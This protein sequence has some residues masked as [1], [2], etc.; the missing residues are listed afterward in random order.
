MQSPPSH[1]CL[2]RNLKKNSIL[3]SFLAAFLFTS[4]GQ[5]FG[6]NLKAA[7]VNDNSSFALDI[8]YE[9]GS[10]PSVLEPIEAGLKSQIIFTIQLCEK[11]EGF[12]SFLGDIVLHEETVQY[13]G[14]KDFF[15]KV[16][17][18]EDAGGEKT[19][20][21]NAE[22]FFYAFRTLR[23]YSVN[24]Y[25]P[26]EK[27]PRLFFRVQVTVYQVKLVAPLT[28][29]YSFSKEGVFESGWKTITFP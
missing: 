16:Y 20:F 10:F 3:L 29:I 4:I 11:R 8:E 22:D 19:V 18:L 28:L 5:G 12:F 15:E 9:F 13:V 24:H 27:T 7:F 1:N 17:V 25:L 2:R 14:H 6:D 23:R 21:A 26:S